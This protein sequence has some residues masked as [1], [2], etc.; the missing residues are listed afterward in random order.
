MKTKNASLKSELEILRKRLLGTVTY[1]FNPKDFPGPKYTRT[2]QRGNICET[3][4]ISKEE[5]EAQDESESY[6]LRGLTPNL[7]KLG[8]HNSAI[9]MPDDKWSELCMAV[10]NKK[11]EL[12]ESINHLICMY[13]KSLGAVAGKAFINGANIERE[14]IKKVI[15]G[16][17]DSVLCS[18][19]RVKINIITS[20]SSLLHSKPE[21]NEAMIERVSKLIDLDFPSYLPTLKDYPSLW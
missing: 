3:V 1:F 5:F 21:T 19:N 2:S 14:V 17:N 7:L 9:Y 10:K 8:A 18:N 16:G 13:L 6:V 12:V 15:E 11:W 20:P 4:A